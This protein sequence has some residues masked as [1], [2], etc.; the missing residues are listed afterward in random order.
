MVEDG[1]YSPKIDY[2][3][4]FWGAFK[5]HYRFKSYGDFAEWVNFAYWLSFSGQ[6]F[7]INGATRSIFL[8]VI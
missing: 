2:V 8:F 4:K 7:A 1:A 5:L 6:G 3:T